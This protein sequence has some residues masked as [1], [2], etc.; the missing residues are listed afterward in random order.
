MRYVLPQS[1]GSSRA[2]L[3]QPMHSTCRVAGYPIPGSDFVKARD[4][5][6]PCANSPVKTDIA[7][8]AT[9]V[10]SFAMRS[11]ALCG[12]RSTLQFA[13]VGSETSHLM[14]EVGDTAFQRF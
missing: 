3:D 6:I 1:V 14:L 9:I 2:S 10:E 4:A 5:H 12:R 11:A 7:G 8:M 13:Q